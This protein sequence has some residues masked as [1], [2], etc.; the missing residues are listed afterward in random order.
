MAKGRKTG[1]RKAGTPNK[2]TLARLATVQRALDEGVTPLDVMI[3]AMQHHYTRWKQPPEGQSD[4]ETMKAAELA[5]AAAKDAAP[6]CHARL[7]A[8]E[9]KAEIITPTELT[10]MEFL[11]R[12]LFLAREARE[13]EQRKRALTLEPVKEVSSGA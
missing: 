1:G 7:Q 8:I 6:Y 2:R 13:L 5:L 10:K 9:H 12:V 3:E 4:L 11:R